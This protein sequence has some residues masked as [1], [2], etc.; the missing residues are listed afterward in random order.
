MS[1]CVLVISPLRIGLGHIVLLVGNGN[2]RLALAYSYAAGHVLAY[3]KV[4]GCRSQ[5]LRYKVACL[6][7]EEVTKIAP[8]K[9][10][11]VGV[12]VNVYHVDVKHLFAFKLAC[13]A[14]HSHSRL[15]RLTLGQI[16]RGNGEFA[17][18]TLDLTLGGQYLAI[19]YQLKG[20]IGAIAV[21]EAKHGN[22]NVKICGL[23]YGDELT[24][25]VLLGVFVFLLIERKVEVC[26]LAV[27]VSLAKAYSEDIGLLGKSDVGDKHLPVKIKIV[28]VGVVALLLRVNVNVA[29]YVNTVCKSGEY[30]LTV[31]VRIEM[32]L[33]GNPDR[34]GDLVALSVL[35]DVF[36]Q[37]IDGYDHVRIGDSGGIG[38]LEGDEIIVGI[39]RSV[40][41][42]ADR[43]KGSDIHLAPLIGGC[44]GCAVSRPA[45]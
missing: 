12:N 37:R 38:A 23:G 21:P 17:G 7:K 16:L 15:N 19:L 29:S 3:I 27:D 45:R 28:I 5:H 26:R 43:L 22:Y 24:A 36:L 11:V 34:G 35:R 14:L 30:H 42:L 25:L 8:V 39:N 40:G 2:Y 6:V 1:A 41:D 13:V 32:Y 33:V 44:S 31:T 20:G 10:H 4:E 9:A 18:V